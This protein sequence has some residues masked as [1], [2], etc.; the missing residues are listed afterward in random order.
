MKPLTRRKFL[1]TASLGT[2]AASLAARLQ[3]QSAPNVAPKGL[4]RGPKRPNLLF[5][6][7]DQHRGDTVPWAGNTAV[8]ASDFFAPLGE[9]SFV[10][11]RA[12]IAQ[13]VCTP[14]RGSIMSGLWPH[15][16]GAVNNNQRYRAGVRTLAERLPSDYATAYYGKWHLGDE[17]KAQHGFQDWRSI[18]D[19][20]RE[21]YRDSADLRKFSDY[22]DFLLSAGFPPDQ[23]DAGTD[24]SPVFSRNLAAAMA[25]PYTKVAFLANEAEKFLEARRDG[26]PFVLYVNSLEPHPPTY[27]PLNGRHDP[28]AMPAGSAFARHGITPPPRLAQRQLDQMAAKGYKNHPI[29]TEHDWRRLRANY[30]GLVSMVDRAYARVIRALEASGQADNTIVVYTSDHGDMCG[31][32]CLMQKGNFY[33]GS[34]HVPLSIHVPWLS[35]RRVDFHGPVS[36]VDLVPTLLDLMGADAGD[37]MDGRSRAAALRDPDSW[38][39]ENICVEW[40]DVEEAAVSGRCRVTADG[41]KLNLYRDDAPE[42]YDLNTDPGELSNLAALPAQSER[43]RLL[44]DEI[45]AWQHATR[46]D[47]PLRS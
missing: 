29:S 1:R 5:L 15:N 14:S 19:L 20:Y 4:A 23:S 32:H 36:T 7:T 3:A 30:Y 45:H 31:D 13:P 37:A 6:W 11:H 28:A 16:H 44:T 42:L 33:E 43:I 46:D 18:E 10:F 9:R 2:V 26:Q 39:R 47:L 38:R 27:G 35:R 22:H 34:I 12:C 24:G 21:F 40:N 25:E 8:Q 17:N 41:W